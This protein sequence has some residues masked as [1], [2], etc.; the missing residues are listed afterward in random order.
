VL[1]TKAALQAA[2]GHEHEELELLCDAMIQ[3]FPGSSHYAS[4]KTEMVS[5]RW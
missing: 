4:A 2:E 1:F 5:R 3:G